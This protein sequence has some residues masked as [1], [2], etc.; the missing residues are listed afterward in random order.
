[1]EK[2]SQRGVFPPRNGVASKNNDQILVTFSLFTRSRIRNLITFVM[3]LHYKQDVINKKRKS[4][5]STY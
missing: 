2:F 1:M 5:N 4:R 3:T